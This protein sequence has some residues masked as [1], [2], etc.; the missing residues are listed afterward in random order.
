MSDKLF[1]NIYYNIFYKICHSKE[2]KSTPR[3]QQEINQKATSSWPN[4]PQT[5]QQHIP[6]HLPHHI[7]Q[8]TEFVGAQTQQQRRNNHKASI[9]QAESNHNAISRWR[10]IPHR[11]QPHIPPTI[12]QHMSQQRAFVG[13]SNQHS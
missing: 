2:L 9:Q 10:I 1:H 12:P 6:Q 11:I 7:P 8:H 4:I 5:N 3:R 13:H